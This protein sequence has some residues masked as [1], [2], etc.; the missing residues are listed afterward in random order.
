MA[1]CGL[2]LEKAVRG[3]M[4]HEKR[5]QAPQMAALLVM[6]PQPPHPPR[7]IPQETS[8]RGWE[9]GRGGSHPGQACPAPAPLERPWGLSAA[10]GRLPRG[11]R[12][13][14][15][16]CGSAQGRRL[17]V[18]T[19]NILVRTSVGMKPLHAQTHPHPTR[20]AQ[21]LRITT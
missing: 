3:S 7:A 8:K 18:P 5:T 19:A 16:C 20:D 2:K 15:R 4:A 14:G 10:D 11:T 12:V 6:S 21:K 9:K 13:P 17:L 1:D